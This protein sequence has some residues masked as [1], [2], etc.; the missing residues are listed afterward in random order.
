[1]SR[2]ARAE[3]PGR[4]MPSPISQSA[5]SAV[6]PSSRCLRQEANTSDTDSFRAPGWPAYSSAA[7]CSVTAWVNSWP[8]TSTGFVNRPKTR[9]SPSPNTSWVP[10]QNALS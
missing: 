2:S 8:S 9:P 1:M 6:C 10:S 7:V 5:S 4:K 3:T